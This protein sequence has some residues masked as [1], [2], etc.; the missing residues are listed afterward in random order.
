LRYL[1]RCPNRGITTAN[2]NVDTGIDDLRRPVLVLIGAAIKATR[3]DDKISAFDEAF[4]PQP[5]E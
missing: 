2:E 3:V 5:I 1:L 4:P